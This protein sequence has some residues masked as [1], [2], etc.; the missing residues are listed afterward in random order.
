MNRV[1]LGGLVVL[2]LV[3][4]QVPASA[5]GGGDAQLRSRQQI[6][7]MEKV[8][9]GAVQNGVDNLR[10]LVRAIMPDDALVQA[11]LPEV[12]GF[13]IEGFG[14]FF[15]VEVPALRQ[16]MAWTLQ[17]M[18][19]SG[20]LLAR[21]LQQLRQLVA[22]MPESNMKAQAERAVQNIQ[23]QI[24]PVGPAAGQGPLERQA[25]AVPQQGQVTA[26]SVLPVAAAASA[27]SVDPVLLDPN[28]AYTQEVKRALTDAMILYG[29]P[30]ALGP[31]E[32]L[33]VAAKDNAPVNPLLQAD[34][35]FRT[36]MLRIKGSDLI[37][38]QMGRL[39]LEQVR[40]RV[41]IQEF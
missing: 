4:A 12:R 14:V 17:Q 25:Q 18:N 26:Q 41:S 37:E 28:E 6:S 32:W 40:A 33:T 16:S 35:D 5:Q 11:S 21:D 19:Q 27:A 39:T 7:M 9:E 36:I 34:A 8:L 24:G 29:A 10:Q 22:S 30:L 13:P 1:L 20:V 3:T 15:D 23:R 31:N 38:Y 2:G